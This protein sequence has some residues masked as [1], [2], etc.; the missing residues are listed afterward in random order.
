MSLDIDWREMVS[1]LLP[2]FQ[3]IS[4]IIDWAE[5]RGRL[6]ELIRA[7]LHA[8]PNAIDLQRVGEKVGIT[9]GVSLETLEAIRPDLPDEDRAAWQTHANEVRGQICIIQSKVQDS[10]LWRLGTDS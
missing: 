6:E 9:T 7:M 4:Q 3:Q 5:R 10:D 2:Y 1:D 8:N